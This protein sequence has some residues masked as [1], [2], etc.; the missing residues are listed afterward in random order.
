MQ[1][2]AFKQS[3]GRKNRHVSE[4][5]K[6]SKNLVLKDKT[7]S[8]RIRVKGKIFLKCRGYCIHHTLLIIPS[9]VNKIVLLFQI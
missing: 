6:I 1:N 9:T 7:P 2:N 8:V 4:K 5:N 3:L